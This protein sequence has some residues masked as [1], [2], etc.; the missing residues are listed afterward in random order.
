MKA[1][2]I[3]FALGLSLTM[4]LGVFAAVADVKETKPVEAVSSTALYFVNNTGETGDWYFFHWG[5]SNNSTWPGEQ[6]AQMSDG[7]YE[8]PMTGWNDC[9]NFIINNGDGGTWQTKDMEKAWY[10]SVSGDLFYYVEDGGHS[11]AVTERHAYTY[12]VDGGANYNSMKYVNGFEVASPSDEDLQ[13][14]DTIL[15]KKDGSALAVTPKDDD[16]L[17][18][19]YS[20]DG[21]LTMGKPY[22]GKLYLNVGTNKL[23]AGQLASGYY[24]AGSNTSWNV[25]LA[26]NATKEPEVNCYYVESVVLA[27]NA[28]IKC[29]YVP[30]DSNT[31][32][33]Y[34]A[35]ENKVLTSTE[36]EYSV[37]GDNNLVVTNAGTYDIYYNTD[38]EYY[39]IEDCN[40]V[41]PTY[42]VFTNGEAYALTLNTGTE[43]QTEELDVIA[44]NPVSVLRNGSPDNSFNLKGIGNNNVTS[45]KKVLVNAENV[46]I[47]VDLDAK[48]I[49]VGGIN[50]YTGNNG[51]HMIQN[52]EFVEMTHYKEYEGFDQYR[53]DSRYFEAGDKVRF[54]DIKSGSA[55][56]T[57]F[58][59]TTINAGG[60]GDKF[61]VSAGQIVCITTCSCNVYL[62]LKFE[63]DEIYFGEVEQYIADAVAYAKGFISTIG[64]ICEDIEGGNNRQTQ[65]E[66]AWAAQATAYGSLT[67]ESKEY[68]ADGQESANQYVRDFDAKYVRVYTLRKLGSGW[69]LADFLEKNLSSNNIGLSINRSID[70]NAMIAIVAISAVSAISVAGL[71]LV[72]KRRKHDK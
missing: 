9:A 53:T 57:V 47:Y 46:R 50:P 35:D 7:V 11:L 3:F 23:W 64:E 8:I 13:V 70:N 17:T 61:A 36:V 15:F 27:A 29:I 18:N 19:V 20:N 56:P 59:I 48:T 34:N 38:T 39:S 69:N 62:K 49:F 44:G 1:K 40:W 58:D 42:T 12:S 24:F 14:G 41:A 54:I 4:G 30:N 68:L 22:N 67:A 6:M 2:H 65:M 45:D 32:T 51:Y 60:L 72:L 66:A 71:L 16:L 21:T 52:G 43:Y 10:A 28:T 31:P 55:I 63:A 26:L 25:K 37:D 33:Y 5:G